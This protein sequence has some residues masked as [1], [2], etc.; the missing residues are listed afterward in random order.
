M[1]LFHFDMKLY[2]LNGSLEET[3]FVKQPS[4]LEIKCKEENVYKLH[5]DLYGLKQAPRA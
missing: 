4:G 3:M 5:K 1:P 2:F